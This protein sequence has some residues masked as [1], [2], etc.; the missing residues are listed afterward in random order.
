M[1][2]GEATTLKTIGAAAA[3]VVIP[4]ISLS[5][6]SAAEREM[7]GHSM[8]AIHHTY[9]PAHHAAA[10]RDSYARMDGRVSYR[11]EPGYAAPEDAYAYAPA[12][13]PVYQ[14]GAPAYEYDNGPYGYVAPGHVEDYNV[15]G[16]VGVYTPRIEP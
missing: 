11:D 6:A 15:G 1:K 8:R 2:R 5:S 4:M 10:M 3:L 14:W 9:G 16:Y 12:P 13:A 7:N